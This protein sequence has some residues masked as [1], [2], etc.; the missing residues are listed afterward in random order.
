[1]GTVTLTYENW[2]LN[3]MHC[4]HH[5]TQNPVRR[6]PPCIWRLWDTL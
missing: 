4:H 6:K 2:K 1:M 5:K 3:V